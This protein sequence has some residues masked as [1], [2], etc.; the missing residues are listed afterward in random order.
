MVAQLHTNTTSHLDMAFHI[1]I[2]YSL[3]RL[4]DLRVNIDTVLVK[5][6][7]VCTNM[8]YTQADGKMIKHF[9]SPR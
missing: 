1:I 7:A 4:L 2:E 5:N 8:D 3:V 9:S 6:L